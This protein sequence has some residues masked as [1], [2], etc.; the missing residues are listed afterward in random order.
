MPVPAVEPNLQLHV[1]LKGVVIND[2]RGTERQFYAF[3]NLRSLRR[4]S[5]ELSPSCIQLLV[6]IRSSMDR[7]DAAAT[8]L[9][10]RRYH[11]RM[12]NIRRLMLIR[13]MRRTA[14]RLRGWLFADET[15]IVTITLSATTHVKEE[16]AFFVPVTQILMGMTAALDKAG[17]RV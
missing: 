8:I 2:R 9:Y 17:L 1:H 6:M 4:A 3:P 11:E 7:I 16:L 10:A 14:R 13:E 12:V 15:V 5:K